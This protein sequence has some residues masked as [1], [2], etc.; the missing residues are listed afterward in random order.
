MRRRSFLGGLGT[1]AA[2]PLVAQGQQARPVIGF[3]GSVSPDLYTVRLRAFHQ[4][5]KMTG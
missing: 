1:T 3:L 5:L 2:W 4:G